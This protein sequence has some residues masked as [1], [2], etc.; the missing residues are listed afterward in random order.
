MLHHYTTL[1]KKLYHGECKMTLNDSL[2]QEKFR[3]FMG[4]QEYLKK[5]KDSYS[6]GAMIYGT[7]LSFRKHDLPLNATGGW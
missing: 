4:Q 1:M 2:L 6:R 3:E 5:K 7:S